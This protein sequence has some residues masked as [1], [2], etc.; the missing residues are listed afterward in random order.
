MADPTASNPLSTISSRISSCNISNSTELFNT[1]QQS[2]SLPVSD[3]LGNVRNLA[4]RNAIAQKE[5][6]FYLYLCSAWLICM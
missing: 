6:K 4:E 2:L 5:S 3:Y 1:T